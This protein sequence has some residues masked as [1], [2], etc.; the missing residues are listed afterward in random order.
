MSSSAARV[1]PWRLPLTYVPAEDDARCGSDRICSKLEDLHPPVVATHHHLLAAVT[2]DV[3]HTQTR[4]RC[5]PRLVILHEPGTMEGPVAQQLHHAQSTGGQSI[6]E[7]YSCAGTD[8]IRLQR[9]ARQGSHG[10]TGGYLDEQLRGVYESNTAV[11]TSQHGV[12]VPRPCESC[13]QQLVDVVLGDVERGVLAVVV[14]VVHVLTARP[15]ARVLHCDVLNGFGER[16]G[17]LEELFA[18]LAQTND[19]LAMR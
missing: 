11:L 14:Q 4:D 18:L 19:A 16:G 13:D 17:H 5:A 15:D 9:Y 10:I 2:V 8:V 3:V 6:D 12:P 1:M 7:S